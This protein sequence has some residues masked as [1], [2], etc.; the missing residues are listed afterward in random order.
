MAQAKNYEIPITQ[1]GSQSF[2]HTV[3]GVKHRV[4]LRYVFATDSYTL[5]LSR[6]EGSFERSLISGMPLV[7]GAD[8]FKQYAYL[9]VGQ[10]SVFPAT[11][12]FENPTGEAVTSDFFLYIWR[13]K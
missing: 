1:K 10:F 9:G 13:H 12:D 3:D 7:T 11:G 4:T 2:T 8:L 6:F 5:N